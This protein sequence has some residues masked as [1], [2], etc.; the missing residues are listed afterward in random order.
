VIGGMFSPTMFGKYFLHERLAVG[1][2]AEIFKA[3]MYGIDGFEKNMVVKQILPQ[4]SRHK[5]F[6][7]MFIDE[8]KI[9]VSLSHGNIVP[10]F[11]LGETDGIYYIA[12]E[13]ID[14]KSLGEVMDAGLDLDDR[15]SI[16]H[17]LFVC[18][19]MLSGLDYAHRKTDEKGAPLGIVHRDISPQNIL[20]SFEGEVKIVDFGI[21]RAATKVHETRAGVIKGKFGYMSPEQA[22]GHDVDNRSDVFAAGILFYEML[23]LE[24]LFQGATDG[25]TLDRV[26]RAD[27]PTPSRFNPKLPPQLD[28]I[29]FKALARKPEDRYQTAGEMRLAASRFL[30]AQDVEASSQTLSIY[31]K[32]LFAEELAERQQQPPVVMPAQAGQAQAG[33]AQVGQAQVVPAMVAPP[34]VAAVPVGANPDALFQ[35][36][37]AGGSNPV[38][39]PPDYATFDDQGDIDDD[40]SY[41]R[42]GRKV[43]WIIGLVILGLLVAGG[44]MFGKDILR[45]FT[46]VSNVIDESA[47]RLAQK[48]LG[49]LYVRSRPTGAAVYFANQKVGTTDM[50]IGSVDPTREYE[51]VLT[52][53]GF[54]PYSRKI[55]P[56]DW[57][58]DEQKMVIQMFWDFTADG[59]R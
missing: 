17:A 34:A 50:R 41:M 22:L 8:A 11:E 42:S 4:Y 38:A 57:K 55:L 48:Q 25:L 45:V 40:F 12:M 10:V 35:P 2:M 23:T 52:L 58:Q 30:Y 20:I 21:A 3:K 6:I 53:E 33:Q 54:K 14:G 19:E 26:K 1:G 36:I 24:R 32:G 47:E 13:Q 59:L 37:P 46:T 27:V 9:T 5:D 29:V 7:Q 15:L 31:L 39:V 56:T 16:P 18:N 43:K 49:Q 28:A 51:L 44:V